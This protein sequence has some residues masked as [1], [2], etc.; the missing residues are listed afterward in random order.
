MKC[1]CINVSHYGLGGTGIEC[2]LV[3]LSAPIQNGPGACPA[4]YSVGTGFFLGVNWSSHGIE[5]PAPS[6]HKVTERVLLYCCSGLSW[7]V[8]G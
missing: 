5:H 7:A 8:L 2:Q 1:I 6:S 4:S 3:G